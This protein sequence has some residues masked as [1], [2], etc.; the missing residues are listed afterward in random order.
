MKPKKLNFWDKNEKLLKEKKGF[1]LIE[2]FVFCDGFIGSRNEWE[3]G[4]Q[5]SKV[6]QKHGF[7]LIHRS[8]KLQGFYIF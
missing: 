4:S 2:K 7:D 5:M 3:N 8:N 1:V 6:V